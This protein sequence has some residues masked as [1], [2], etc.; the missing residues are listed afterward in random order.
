ML[1]EH[2]IN[3]ESDE[4]SVDSLNSDDDDD[5]YSDDSEN[6]DDPYIPKG[7]L[8]GSVNITIFLVYS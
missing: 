4:C 6:C 2:I 8:Q 1:P 5:D 3:E 7:S